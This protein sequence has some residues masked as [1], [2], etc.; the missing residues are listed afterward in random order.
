MSN[1]TRNFPLGGM[2]KKKI[3]KKGCQ[4]GNFDCSTFFPCIWGFKQPEK[5][6]IKGVPSNFF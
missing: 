3:A 4:Q 5:Y 2:K 6:G 1:S